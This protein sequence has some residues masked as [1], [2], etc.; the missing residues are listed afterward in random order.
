M[1]Y[2]NF[3]MLPE[4]SDNSYSGKITGEKDLGIIES[5]SMDEL[6][7]EFQKTVDDYLEEKK[8]RGERK[9]KRAVISILIFLTIIISMTATCPTKDKHISAFSNQLTAILN[10]SADADET[11]LA[12]IGVLFGNQ[13][14]GALVSHY[15]VI[16]DCFIFNVGKLHYGGKARIV[17]IG[18]FGH[19]FTASQ[20]Q[21]EEA[22]HN[23]KD[24]QELM[25]GLI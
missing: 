2:K 13:I 23:D 7:K 20:K 6:T 18:V 12:A 15:L 22:V 19:V 14:I 25:G 5:D 10:D 11:G 24:L 4:C 1:K 21:I 9:R 17:S 3:Y 16:D 8:V